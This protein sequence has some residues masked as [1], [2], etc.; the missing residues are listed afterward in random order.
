MSRFSEII[1]SSPLFK[2]FPDNQLKQIEETL[3]ER[4]EFEALL[5]DLSAR[6]VLVSPEE[7]DRTIEHTLK[8]IQEFFQVDRCALMRVSKE[9][10][11][12]EDLPASALKF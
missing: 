6:F 8:E 7:M 2:G 11:S 12:W 10:D 9:K 3:K 5:S 4:L 1:L